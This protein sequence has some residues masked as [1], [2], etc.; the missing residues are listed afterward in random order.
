M[1]FSPF[2]VH[3]SLREYEK[4]A[5]LPNMDG[6]LSAGHESVVFLTYYRVLL[7]SEALISNTTE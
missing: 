7:N 1:Y 6:F 5:D 4:V 2:D 3:I